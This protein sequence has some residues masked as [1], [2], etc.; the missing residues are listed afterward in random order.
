MNLEQPDNENG[1]CYC[2]RPLLKHRDMSGGS[3]EVPMIAIATVFHFSILS[4]TGQVV[5]NQRQ[6]GIKMV[7]GRIVLSESKVQRA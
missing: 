2:R 1:M 6:R 5:S 4:N 7:K 3:R